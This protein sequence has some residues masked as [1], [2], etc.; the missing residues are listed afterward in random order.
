MIFDY[1]ASQ[2]IAITLTIESAKIRPRNRKKND[3]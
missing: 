1:F 3:E 2:P